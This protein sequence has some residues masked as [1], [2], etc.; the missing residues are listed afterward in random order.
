MKLKN[1]KING[2]FG[3]YDYDLHFSESNHYI[4]LTSPNGYGKT[5][6]LNII[7]SLA[8]SDLYFFYWL[9]FSTIELNFVDGEVL[10]VESINIIPETKEGNER[11]DVPVEYNR[12]VV[13][14]WID[15]NGDKSRFIINDKLISKAFRS[16]GYYEGKRVNGIYPFSKEFRE[17]VR[18][19][20][21]MLDLM[22]REQNNS[23]FFLQVRNINTVFIEAQRIFTAPI[24]S[25]QSN[26]S[27]H[28]DR[29][30]SMPQY[31]INEVAE[32]I[33]KTLSQARYLY[34]EYSQKKGNQLISRLLSDDYD[35][36]TCEEYQKLR[37][38]L[39]IKANELKQYGL[40]DDVYIP[41]YNSDHEKELSVNITEIRDNFCQL[42]DV[43]AKVKLFSNL[44]NRKHFTAKAISFS[45]EK[46]LRA[47]AYDQKWLEL[48]DLSSGEQNVIIMLYYLVFEYNKNKILLI[49][50]PE[51][52][53]HVAWQYQYIDELE[54]IMNVNDGQAIIATHSPQ[55]IGERWDCCIDLTEQ[56]RHE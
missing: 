39:L 41:E 33:K 1:I 27:V 37:S 7:N 2:L 21:R 44:I 25:E 43:Y 17:F 49:D 10:S 19:N 13:F 24:L 48:S 5:T 15:S 45:R 4:I 20:P 35:I 18:Q 23:A 3:M 46:G 50:E 26:F 42:D 52:S 12:E 8:K 28:S 55:I 16:I 53:L 11:Q 56:E 54:E 14:L 9:N 6:I 38:E 22:A 30:S 34:L 36:L 40:I 29:N 51:I 31:T 32:K 47:M